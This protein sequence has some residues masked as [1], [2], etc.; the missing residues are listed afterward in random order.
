MSTM[1]RM[2]AAGL[3]A[4]TLM[5]PPFGVAVTNQGFRLA[6]GVPSAHAAQV[7]PVPPPILIPDLIE[8]GYTCGAVAPDLAVCSKGPG[9][10][11][12]ECRTNTPCTIIGRQNQTKFPPAKSQSGTT[13]SNG[14]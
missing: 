11:T 9:Y 14:G 13:R 12:Y 2:L 5:V 3:V 1:T 6:A 10:P 8:D 4:L 7:D